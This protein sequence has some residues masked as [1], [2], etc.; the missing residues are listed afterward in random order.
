MIVIISPKSIMILMICETGTPSAL[1]E[2]LDGDARDDRDGSGRRDDLARLLRRRGGAVA[3]GLALVARALADALDHDAAL[4][5]RPRGTLT[6][7]HGRLGLLGSA[8]SSAIS[9]SVEAREPRLDCDGPPQ[10]AIE[11]RLRDGPLEAGSRR[12]V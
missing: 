10:C 9:A 1:R 7:P 6:G 4:A 3:R 2:V 11:A 5:A 12:Q 8:A